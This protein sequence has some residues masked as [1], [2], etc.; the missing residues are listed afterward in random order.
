M[1][2]TYEKGFEGSYRGLGL[3]RVYAF[4]N[5]RLKEAPTK[6]ATLPFRLRWGAVY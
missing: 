3:Q 6:K 2:P 1:L 4:S 5:F